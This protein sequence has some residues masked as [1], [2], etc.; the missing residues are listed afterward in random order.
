MDG[1]YSRYRKQINEYPRLTEEDEIRLSM[2]LN[3]DSSEEKKQNAINELIVCNLRLV[4]TA[5]REVYDNIKNFCRV[6]PSLMDLIEE[7]NIGLMKA[8]K[9]FD[10]EKGKFSTYAY[11]SIRSSILRKHSNT[12]NLIRI[13]PTHYKLISEIKSVRKK[14]GKNVSDEKIM[15]E[16]GI[17]KTQLENVKCS[18]RNA[19]QSIEDCFGT[20]DD[21]DNNNN[22]LLD[23]YVSDEE[24]IHDLV[25]GEEQREYMM[26]KISKLTKREQI[27]ITMHFFDNLPISS[28]QIIDKLKITKQRVHI[29]YQEALFKLKKMI[30]FDLA[31]KNVTLSDGLTNKI[32]E[33]KR[34]ERERNDR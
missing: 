11:R 15:A 19:V 1:T 12:N 23:I 25:V 18:E 30:A 29:V 6:T 32:N 21:D 24:S 26:S 8:A 34:E 7:G 22:N 20:H 14:Y 4:I 16:T 31:M 10:I 28:Q 33:E 9:K 17:N 5:A 27:I 13:P 2:V 3:G